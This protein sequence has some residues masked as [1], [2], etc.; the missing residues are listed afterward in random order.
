MID[1]PTRDEIAGIQDTIEEYLSAGLFGEVDDFL[2]KLDVTSMAADE[3]FSYL[4]ATAPAREHLPT[5]K[6]LYQRVE[7]EVR[8]RWQIQ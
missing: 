1:T 4:E 3:M 2:R 5:R 7:T 8:S 6:Y